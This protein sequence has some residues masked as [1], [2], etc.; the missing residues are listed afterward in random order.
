MKSSEW[1]RDSN[2]K[3]GG[4]CCHGRQQHVGGGGAVGRGQ[5]R[6]QG[7]QRLVD[8]E[9]EQGDWGN[10]WLWCSTLTWEDQ[11]RWSTAE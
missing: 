11:R 6:R 2:H 1:W 8:G 10:H 5:G 9:H 7:Q 4:C 3:S